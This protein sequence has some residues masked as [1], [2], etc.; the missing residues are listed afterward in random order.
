NWLEWRDAKPC[1]EEVGFNSA[2]RNGEPFEALMAKKKRTPNWQER[3]CTQYLKVEPMLA[4]M[5]AH[6]YPPG[7]FTEVIGMRHDEGHRILKGLARAEKDGRHVKYPLAK[8][9][10]VKSDVFAFWA[11]QKFDLGLQPWEGNCDLCFLKGRKIRKRIIRN[12]PRR[13]AW[14]I[15]EE[16]KWGFFDRRDRVHELVTEVHRSPELD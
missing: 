12:E 10:V 13:A 4:F 5:D 15:T 1:F 6:G 14:W 2:S 11:E 8:A 9:K 7:T 16:A 3:W